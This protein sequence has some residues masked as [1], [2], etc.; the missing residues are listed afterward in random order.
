MEKTGGREW[1]QEVRRGG[2]CSIQV[3]DDGPAVSAGVVRHGEQWLD[4][5]PLG[6]ELVELAAGCEG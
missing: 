4:W 2:S 3:R 5:G 1:K 6:V